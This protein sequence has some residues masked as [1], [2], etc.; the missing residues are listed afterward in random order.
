MDMPLI[1]IAVLL[2]GAVAMGSVYGYQ[3]LVLPRRI[4]RS[5]ILQ[6]D[7]ASGAVP[8]SVLRSQRSTVP[9]VD[10]LPLSRE[11]RQK[12]AAE[13]DRAG[14]P[15]RVQEYLAL[16][17]ACSL[18]FGL[19]GMILSLRLGASGTVMSLVALGFLVPGWRIPRMYL[20]RLV[21]RRQAQV[22]E[23]LPE[24]LTS[25]AK[26]LRAGSGLL[27]GLAFAARETPE[28]LG[29]ELQ[30]TLSELQLGRDT[31]EA[32]MA[33]SERVGNA[34]LDIAVTAILIQRTAGGNLSEILTNVTSTIRERVKLQR[35]IAVLTARQ[36]LTGTLVALLPVV[37]GLA[38][39]AMNPDTAKL[40]FTESAG[41]ISLAI[42]IGFEIL[43]LWMIRRLQQIEY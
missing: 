18:L 21:S 17:I 38:F 16:R 42:G 7:H 30:Q 31:E 1:A 14:R 28:P 26:A 11:S 40:L 19:A 9:F 3:A 27:Q 29:A 2:G 22:A 25:I 37:V 13:L 10:L 24:A 5:R 35:E 43:G 23:Q 8:I 12:M 33:L 32:F 20:Q 34:D 15:F 4:T 41:R 36:R 39:L 6:A